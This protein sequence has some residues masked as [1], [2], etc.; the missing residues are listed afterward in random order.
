M[1]YD[2]STLKAAFFFKDLGANLGIVSGLLNA[3]TP[4]RVRLAAGATMNFVGYLLVYLAINGLHRAAARAADVPL[5]LRHRQLADLRQH[6]LAR[7]L[8]QELA[9]EPWG[10]PDEL[11]RAPH[12]GRAFL[13]STSPAGCAPAEP[14]F[15]EQRR[16]I[17]TL[18][19]P[20]REA[21]Y[22]SVGNF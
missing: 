2:Q 13:S 22:S 8:R 7:H 18:A 6:L 16:C 14:F 20:P 17:Y 11:H 19:N 10:L 1:C 3:V 15:G 12:T 5:H 21:C 4:P 9:A